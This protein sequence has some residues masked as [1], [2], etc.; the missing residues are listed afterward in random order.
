MTDGDA[1]LEKVPLVLLTGPSGAGRSTAI[2]A[3][4][5]AGFETIDNLP[6]GLLPRLLT[7][8][9]PKRPM[10][11]SLDVRNRDFSPTAIID[12]LEL[13]DDLPRVAPELLYLDC[14]AEVLRRRYNETRRNHPLDRTEDPNDGIERELTLLEDVRARATVLMETSELTPHELRHA[15]QSRFAPQKDQA[16]GITVQSFSYKRGLPQGADLVLDCRFLHN[17]HW[18]KELRDMDGSDAPVGTYIAT[19]SGYDPFV[20]SM[21]M[22]LEHTLPGYVREGR[23]HLQI[24]FGCTGGKHRSVFMAETIAESLANRGWR[25]SIRHRELNRYAVLGARPKIAEDGE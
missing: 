20:K 23:S 2:K 11:L 22:V 7:G 4:E 6:L 15:V 13:V 5:D 24:A 8:Q 3:L 10:A 19:D 25:V 18:K 14:R 16:I 12:A 1:L 21:Q 9:P 17:P